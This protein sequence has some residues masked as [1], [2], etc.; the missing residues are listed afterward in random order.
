M[1]AEHPTPESLH[2]LITGSG[3]VEQ[4]PQLLSSFGLSGRVFIISDSTVLPLYGPRVRGVLEAE[5]WGVE[6]IAVPVGEESKSVAEAS[7]L[8]D[9]LIDQG[10]SRSDIVLALGG[11]V[12]GDLAGWVAATY[13]RG[14]RLVQIPTNLVAMVDSSIGGKT[15]INHPKAKNI[16]GS[17]YPPVVTLIDPVFLGSLSAAELRCGWA[18]A[19]K[20]AL[21]GDLELFEYMERNADRLINLEPE[22]TSHV[23]GTCAQF[24]LRIVTEDPKESGLRAILNYGHTI[25][26]ALENAAGYGTLLHGEGVAI[27][28]R[29]AAAIAR[30]MSMLDERVAMRQNRL[31]DKFELPERCIGLSEERVL[32]SM[33]RDKKM[34]PRGL[35]WVLLRDIAKPELRTDVSQ[36]IVRE[37]IG[38]L[39]R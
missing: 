34:T 3:L 39:I 4:L 22:P 1:S 37:V 36:E 16:I 9:W 6:S 18:E 15:G 32:S 20:T 24:K 33:S 10:A 31:L 12:V 26:H 27:G 13:L 14:I 23:V 7:R 38:A 2:P 25:G 28:M 29:G 35:R 30:K 5:G 19:I 11:G 21:I 17:F 8:W